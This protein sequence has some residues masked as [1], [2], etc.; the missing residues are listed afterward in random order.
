MC[1][2]TRQDWNHPHP[3]LHRFGDDIYSEIYGEA[4]SYA[5][6][7][8]PEDHFRY[9]DWA[10]SETTGEESWRKGNRPEGGKYIPDVSR[11]DD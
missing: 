10:A 8:T 1:K 9:R 7:R 3:G 4:L 2:Q 11:H 6:T 5:M